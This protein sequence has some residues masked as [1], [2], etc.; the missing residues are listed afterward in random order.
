[1]VETPLNSIHLTSLQEW[2]AWWEQNHT[3]SEG[4]WLIGYK[5]ASGKAFRV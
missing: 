2:R 4:I 3:R 5:K 1:M